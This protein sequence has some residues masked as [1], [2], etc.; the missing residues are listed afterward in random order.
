MI[1]KQRTILK[2]AAGDLK[3]QIVFDTFQKLD[4]RVVEIVS[5]EE[6]PKSDKLY[7]LVVNLGF[8]KRAVVSGIRKAYPNPEVLIGKRVAFVA[9]LKPAKLMGIESQG[10]ILSA[11]DDDVLEVVALK[12]APLGSPIT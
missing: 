5:V 8:E 4:L 7:K 3:D 1:E 11:G 9:N 2:E 10:M 12:E 6:V